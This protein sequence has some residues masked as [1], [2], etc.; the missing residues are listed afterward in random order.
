MLGTLS[1]IASGIRKRVPKIAAVAR[2]EMIKAVFPL[3]FSFK[4]L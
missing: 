1:I 4:A 3:S 2:I